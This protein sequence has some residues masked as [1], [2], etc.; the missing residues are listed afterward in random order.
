VEG[1]PEMNTPLIKFPGT[2]FFQVI[3]L[4]KSVYTLTF[5]RLRAAEFEGKPIVLENKEAFL[6]YPAVV[7]IPIKIEKR[8]RETLPIFVSM[9]PEAVTLNYMR[10]IDIDTLSIQSLFSAWAMQELMGN[11]LFVINQLNG[12][13]TFESGALSSLGRDLHLWGLVVRKKSL[14]GSAEEALFEAI[15]AVDGGSKSFSYYEAKKGGSDKSGVI[16]NPID[17]QVYTQRLNEWL[18]EYVRQ[19]IAPGEKQVQ[20][21]RGTELIAPWQ[22]KPEKLAL[23]A[24]YNLKDLFSP[25]LVFS[26]DDIARIQDLIDARKKID[27]QVSKKVLDA[28]FE[29]IKTGKGMPETKEFLPI[30]DAKVDESSHEQSVADLRRLDNDLRALVQSARK[31][32]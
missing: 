25:Q 6:L 17:A 12:T 31:K 26:R 24:K 30:P 29:R 32:K 21:R 20:L 3:N 2:D 7:D 15:F 13:N 1:R 10:M 5:A 14:P 23:Y 8:G 22:V 19:E 28:K 4:N 18:D 9:N 11:K 27:D 16:I